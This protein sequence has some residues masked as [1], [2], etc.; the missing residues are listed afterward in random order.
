MTPDLSTY[1]IISEGFY[2]LRALILHTLNCR[3]FEDL[4]AVCQFGSFGVPW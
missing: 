2:V 4:S 1:E 3:V